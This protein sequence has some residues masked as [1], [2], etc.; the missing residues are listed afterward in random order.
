MLPRIYSIMYQNKMHN[1][2]IKHLNNN[3]NIFIEQTDSYN[4]SHRF[5]DKNER[6]LTATS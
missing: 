3:N 1:L 6:F 5:I 4:K 2:V